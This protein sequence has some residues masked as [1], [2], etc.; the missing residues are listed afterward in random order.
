MNTQKIEFTS[1]GEKKSIEVQGCFPYLLPNGNGRVVLRITANE[2]DASFDDLKALE[3]NETGVIEYYVRDYDG[4]L[5][6]EWILK[7][8]YEG[9]NAGVATIS[10][11]KGQGANDGQYQCDVVRL[12]EYEKAIKQAQADIEYISIMADIPLN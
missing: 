2:A 3:D 12:G 7:D 6:G 8:T 9:Y 11:T 4:E 1:N 10:Y 5:V